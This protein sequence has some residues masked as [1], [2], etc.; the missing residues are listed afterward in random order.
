MCDMTRRYKKKEAESGVRLMTLLH[1]KGSEILKREADNDH[2]IHLYCTGPYW[3]AF[4]KSAY[5]LRQIAPKAQVIPMGLTSYPFPVVMA[6]WIDEEWRAYCRNHLFHQVGDDYC[7]LAV[8]PLSISGFREWHRQV[9][10]DL[11]VNAF[12]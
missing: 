1:E 11:M 10:S 3:V 9:V 4:E 8:T 2:F 5:L 6:C 7:R 12:C